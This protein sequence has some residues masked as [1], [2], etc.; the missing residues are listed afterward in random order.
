MFHLEIRVPARAEKASV[1]RGALRR[2]LSDLALDY[3]R[4]S[5]VLLAAGEATSNAIEHA[6][7]GM[8]EGM[9]FLRADATSER[10][11]IHVRD[12]G[13]WR[14]LSNSGRG[15]G[16]EIMRALVDDLSIE[17]T[18][19]GTLVRLEVRFSDV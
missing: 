18:L 13:C 3:A 5:D 15:R 9:V 2:F 12:S 19:A 1:V 11:V 4:M 16:L 10:I 17:K 8:D 7:E 6:Y 14:M